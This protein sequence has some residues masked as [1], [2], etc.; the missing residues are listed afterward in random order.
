MIKNDV[1]SALDQRDIVEPETDVLVD[2]QKK[3]NNDRRDDHHVNKGGTQEHAKP[4]REKGLDDAF[5]KPFQFSF[6]CQGLLYLC[7]TRVE[8]L[9]ALFKFSPEGSLHLIELFG[10]DLSSLM[11]RFFDIIKTF[12]EGIKELL[13]LRKKILS[14]MT[15]KGV[16]V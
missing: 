11:Q 1:L 10:G 3:I 16:L 14:S 15:Q 6:L 9:D 12:I 2:F 5:F 13:H 7:F 4:E 8:V